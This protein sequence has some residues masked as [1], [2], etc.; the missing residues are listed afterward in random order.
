MGA[1]VDDDGAAQQAR[2][3]RLAV[4][5]AGIGLGRLWMDYFSLGGDAGTVEVDAYLHECLGLPPFQRDLLAH[6][7]NGLL[8]PGAPRAPYSADLPGAPRDPGTPPD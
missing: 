2:L 3:L 6:A 4:E 5:D 1:P 8:R 7:A